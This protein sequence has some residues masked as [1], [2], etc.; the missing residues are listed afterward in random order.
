M[1]SNDSGSLPD[2]FVDL[3][4]LFSTDVDPY[5]RGPSSFST[6]GLFRGPLEAA[7]AREYP[8]LS[9]DINEA[10]PSIDGT[11][12][13][14]GMELAAKARGDAAEVR[15]FIDVTLPDGTVRVF[16]G[17]NDFET[18]NSSYGTVMADWKRTRAYAI[19][20]M[21]KPGLSQVFIDGEWHKHDWVMQLNINRIL[22]EHADSY[23]YPEEFLAHDPE[24]GCP[25]WLRRFRDE[26]GGDPSPQDFAKHDFF[27]GERIPNQPI[28]V[29]RMFIGALLKDWNQRDADRA[30][31]YPQKNVVFVEIPRVEDEAILDYMRGRM[32]Y[33]EEYREQPLDDVPRCAPAERWEQESV[34]KVF[35]A[36]SKAKSPRSKANVSSEVQAQEI[37]DDHQNKTGKPH[38]IEHFPGKSM[39]CESYCDYRTVCPF[40][41]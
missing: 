32:E 19:V 41:Q 18:D 21:R 35:D 24:A 13:H 27:L 16:S 31:D 29:D 25:V 1:Y 12:L 22:A 15:R 10:I 17:C 8:D 33:H 6:T 37:A 23:T 20:F 30:E 14:K 11:M 40:N 34:W 28:K 5:T 36:T 38:R 26:I 9:K 4:N 2:F 7:L 3:C 39:K